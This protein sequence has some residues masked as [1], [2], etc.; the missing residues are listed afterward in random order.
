MRSSLDSN[1]EV[2]LVAGIFAAKKFAATSGTFA[3]DMCSKLLEMLHNPATSL[4]VKLKLLPILQHMYH[5]ADTGVTTAGVYQD[6]GQ[7]DSEAGAAE[8][9]VSV[10]PT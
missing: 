7:A 8:R 1:D 6:R 9:L 3:T 5:S 4:P 10:G 2:E